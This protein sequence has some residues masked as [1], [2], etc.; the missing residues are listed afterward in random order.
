[1]ANIAIEIDLEALLSIKSCTI[2]FSREMFSIVCTESMRKSTTDFKI[3]TQLLDVKLERTKVY[4]H[5][6]HSKFS[7]G[8]GG[9]DRK[10]CNVKFIFAWSIKKSCHAKVDFSLHK[11][12]LFSKLVKKPPIL[13]IKWDLYS[14]CSYISQIMSLEVID[15]DSWQKN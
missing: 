9:G 4:K 11:T 5:R 3:C 1:M 10:I 8:W 2:K 12:R 15:L 13:S 14:T 7:A 6:C